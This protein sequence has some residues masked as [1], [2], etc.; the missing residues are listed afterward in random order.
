MVHALL[1]GRGFDGVEGAQLEG[2]EMYRGALRR[3]LGLTWERQEL[4]SLEAIERAVST[5][6]ADFALIMTTFLASPDKVRATFRRLYERVHRPRLIFLDYFAQTSSPYFSV[7]PFVDRYAKRQVL[8]DRGLYH[9]RPDYVFSEWFS[10]TYGFDLDGWGFG[11]TLPPEESHKLVLAWNLAV[12]RSYRRILLG[13]RLLPRRWRKRSIE[14]NT[15]LGLGGASPWE[16]YQEYRTRCAKA[17]VA[18]GSRFRTTGHGRISR[19][20]FQLEMRDSKIAFSPF[21]WGELCFRDY[22]AII[23]GALLFKPSMEHLETR[24]DVFA[25]RRTYVA[26]RWDNGDLEDQCAYYLAH[27]DEAEA[28][29]EG[30]QRRLREY[31]EGEGFVDDVAR[32]MSLN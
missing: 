1:I 17:A 11:S 19:R 22:E 8:R 28:I 13:N 29:V 15:R 4:E 23:W 25:D 31:Y 26:L 3:R 6:K 7:L 10:R 12:T 30:A 27:P 5:T 24:P 16:W 18:L 32:V 14:V 20:R 9:R 2:F 21:G